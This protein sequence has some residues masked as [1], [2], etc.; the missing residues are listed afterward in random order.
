LADQ[1]YPST[2]RAAQRLC[3][4]L[5]L[6][7]LPFELDT[8]LGIGP[9]TLTNVELLLLGALAL[10]AAVL[11]AERRGPAVPP[12]LLLGS[13]VVVGVLLL[14][15][16]FAEAERPGAVKFALR[17][18]QGAALALCLADT[19]RRGGP[20]P[21][22][23]GALLAG[24][25]VSAALGL[26]EMSESPAALALLA[27]FKSEST[28][29]GGLLRLSGTFSYANTA[30]Q[31][32]EAALP[33]AVLVALAATMRPASA[34]PAGRR[35]VATSR[36]LATIAVCAAPLLLL[37]TLLTYSR[38]AL[39]V[40]AL[41]LA[42]TPFVAWRAFGGRAARLGGLACAGLAGLGL[43]LAVASP[44]FR[45]RVSEPE[46]ARWY[47]ARYTPAPL[48]P[49]APNE[50]R[51][52]AIT[53]ENSGQV[54]WEPDGSRPVRLA[55]H[56]LDAESGAIVRYE[57]RRTM[58]PRPVAPGESLSLTATVQAPSEP[59]RYILVWD[60]LREYIGRG[61]FSQMGIDPAR[62]AVEVAGAPANTPPPGADPPRSPS[63][64]AAI[65]GPPGR[66]ELWGV[67][68]DMWR[69]RPLLGVGPDVFRHTYGPRLGLTLWDDRVHTNSLYVELLTGAGVLGLGS[70]LALAGGSLVAGW[71]RLNPAAG[72]APARA[73]LAGALLGVLAFLVHGLLDVFLAFTPTYALLWAMLGAIGGL[74]PWSR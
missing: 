39:A 68:L 64:I 60:M 26:L 4:A 74:A 71:R 43:T 3:L 57:G 69:E 32:Y 33:L 19:L 14:S 73:L 53:V 72:P 16:A 35:G 66:R 28:Y 36:A 15:A 48:A 47:G 42:L 7:T 44:T 50:L 1:A 25:G 70:F 10:W 59:G 20:A 45:L 55:Y 52:V 18:G 21:L 65:P 41:L 67:A 38:A 29:M 22:F 46:V 24:A 11:I 49:M 63:A 31:F 54:A 23:A 34:T 62:V 8:G 58:L 37:A 2:L 61:W 40:T 12:W 30:A 5:C 6:A 17:Q 51:Q 27:P 13:A 56:W 9:L